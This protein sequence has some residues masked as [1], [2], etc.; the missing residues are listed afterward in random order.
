[1]LFVFNDKHVPT[2]YS[3][4]DTLPHSYAMQYFLENFVK[5]TEAQNL[6]VALQSMS[7]EAEDDDEEEQS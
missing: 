4:S 5:A 6:E 2:I 3:N 1:M 7:E